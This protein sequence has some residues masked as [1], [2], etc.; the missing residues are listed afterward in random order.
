[1]F[2]E[3]S[4]FAPLMADSTGSQAALA[5][6]FRIIKKLE[7]M[8]TLIHYE[9]SQQ[10]ITQQNLRSLEKD[11][12]DI[13]KEFDKSRDMRSLLMP[14]DLALEALDKARIN[15][16]LA[17]DALGMRQTLRIRQQLYQYYKEI[18][19]YLNIAIEHM[20]DIR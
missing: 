14:A 19:K 5:R 6:L 18:C 12:R 10:D 2:Y 9:M 16:N 11:L 13:L 15:L 20:P 4:S 17:A 7:G 3:P 8:R 1:M